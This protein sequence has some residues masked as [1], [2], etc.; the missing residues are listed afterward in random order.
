MVRPGV[1]AVAERINKPATLARNAS[2]LYPA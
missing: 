1:P 2:F